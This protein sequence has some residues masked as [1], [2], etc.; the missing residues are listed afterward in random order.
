MVPSHPGWSHAFPQSAAKS[1]ATHHRFSA[2]ILS[3][4]LI[5][6]V[7]SLITFILCCCLISSSSA[8]SSC[9]LCSRCKL[10][11]LNK[12][13]ILAQKSSHH[14]LFLCF[15]L[16]RTRLH[17]SGAPL[18]LKASP[19]LSS[20]LY[21]SRTSASIFRQILPALIHLFLTQTSPFYHFFCVYFKTTVCLVFHFFSRPSIHFLPFFLS[22]VHFT[23]SLLDIRSCTTNSV[24]F[25]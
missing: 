1:S 11:S 18:P 17:S 15:L 10:N 21:L 5:L 13:K 22:F 24:P 19:L 20:I 14:F 2:S 8:K 16:P 12:A 6:F 9:L 25:S 7:V 23:V 3:F 4:G